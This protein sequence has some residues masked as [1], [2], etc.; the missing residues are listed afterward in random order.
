M[1]SIG[2]RSKILFLLEGVNDINTGA[3]ANKIIEGYKKII[4]QAHTSGVRVIAGTIPP[5][6][7]YP[8]WSVKKEKFG[9]K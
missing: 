4:N 1:F 3:S 9:R 6:K 2:L 7:G 5:F 8:T